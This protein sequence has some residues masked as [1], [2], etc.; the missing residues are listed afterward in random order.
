MSN[1][2]KG[3][4]YAVYILAATFFFLYY[5]FPAD[6]AKKYISNHLNETR[7]GLKITID[8]VSPAFPLGL[9]LRAIRL[10]F[11]SDLQ[12]HADQIKIVPGLLSLFGSE[13]IFIFKGRAY[14][15]LMEGRGK[16]TKYGT[17]PRAVI[18]AS[19]SDIR[20]KEISALQ[21]LAGGEISG[22][23]DGK[24]KYNFG[25]GSGAIFSAELDLSD[26]K[27]N[28][29]TPVLTLDKFSFSR[30]EADID[31]DFQKLQIKKCTFK[32]MQM[33]GNL[34][35]LITLKNPIR[36][37]F[38]NISGTIIPQPAFIAKLDSIFPGYKKSAKGDIRIKFSGTLEEPDIFFH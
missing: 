29:S 19:F 4:F 26:C 24:I 32:G 38:L 25:Q 17:V 12:L 2:K 10:Q 28:L 22:L 27:L 6:A 9:N 30:I 13:V 5:L 14:A 34:T 16:M 3:L 36:K 18:D 1:F 15:G 35:G 33:N 23:L 7:P 11:R 37:S 21:D 31:S 8:Q 20:I